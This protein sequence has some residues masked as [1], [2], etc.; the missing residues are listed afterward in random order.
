MKPDAHF[1]VK[2]HVLPVSRALG[3]LGKR[4]TLNFF[5]HKK[6]TRRPGV[7][8]KY[9]KKIF[10]ICEEFLT[11]SRNSVTVFCCVL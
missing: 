7:V 1:V 8:V 4:V 3:N 2:W 10:N 9:K 6:F 5:P 11:H